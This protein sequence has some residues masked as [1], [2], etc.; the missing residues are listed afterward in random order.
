[1]N[2]ELF[3]YYTGGATSSN[4][5]YYLYT[6]QYWW[7]L[8][9]EGFNYLFGYNFL[10]YSSGMLSYSNDTDFSTNGV[11]PAISLSHDLL[12]SRGDGTSENP[13]ELVLE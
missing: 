11:R 10:V 4:N 9:P 8:S 2:C 13:Y 1:M 6:G 5:S 3:V 12:V 7:T